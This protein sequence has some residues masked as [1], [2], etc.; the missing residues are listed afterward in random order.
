[1]GMLFDGQG[2]NYGLLKAVAKYVDNGLTD[3]GIPILYCQKINCFIFFQRITSKN[4]VAIGIDS[5]YR[6][7]IY[8]TLRCNNIGTDTSNNTSL[9]DYAGWYTFDV[10]LGKK[11]MEVIEDLKEFIKELDIKG[12]LYI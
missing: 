12:E 3:I 6:N 1:M 7:H 4:I 2:N 8:V 5:E 11:P 9:G 10:P